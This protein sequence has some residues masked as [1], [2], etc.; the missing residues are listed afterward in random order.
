[1][2]SGWDNVINVQGGYQMI[3]LFAGLP[4]GG[5]LE[6]YTCLTTEQVPGNASSDSAIK[7]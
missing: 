2:N 3:Q 5:V 7:K 1:M 6:Q 4:P